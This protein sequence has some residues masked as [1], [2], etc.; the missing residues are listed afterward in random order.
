MFHFP[1]IVYSSRSGTQIFRSCGYRHYL[2][3]L[4][5]CCPIELPQMGIEHL[6]CDQCNLGTEFFVLL[7]ISSD[8]L[9][10]LHVANDHYIGQCRSINVEWRKD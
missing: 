8:K 1:K 2:N 5:E 7:L 10:Q 9:T 6:K 4:K 3:C